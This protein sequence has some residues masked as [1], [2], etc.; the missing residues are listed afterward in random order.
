MKKTAIRPSF[1][2]ES[3][4]TDVHTNICVVGIGILDDPSE[5]STSTG[6][7]SEATV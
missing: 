2:A 1:F 5:K 7:F 6:D 3:Y 4:F